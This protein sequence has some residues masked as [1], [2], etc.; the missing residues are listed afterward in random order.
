[1][2]RRELL[3]RAGALGLS[4]TGLTA[5]DAEGRGLAP[6]RD[7]RTWQGVRAQW[8][9]D[10][11]RRNLSTFLLAS[12][13]APV[14]EAIARHRA[15]LD[16]NP[17][18]YLDAAEGRLDGA[19]LDA[20]AAYLAVRR[21][22]IAL[23]DSTTMGLGLVYTGFRLRA[24]DEV[25]TSVHDF[26]A[27][28]ESLRFAA[29]RT[30]ATV[31]RIGLYAKP[32]QATEDEIVVNVERALTARTRLVALTWVHSSTG[33][34]L[35]VRAIS[36]AVRT[37]APNALLAIDGVH[38]VGVEDERPATL[39]C[40]IL[41]SG[42][43]KWLFGP[44]GTGFVWAS[45]RAWAQVRPTIPSFDG[46]AYGGWLTGT[47]SDVPPG[48]LMTPGG[49][50]AFEHRWALADAFRFHLA[51]GRGRV[52]ARTHALG[53]RLAEGLAETAGIRLVTPR[54]PALSGGLV[55]FE[56]AGRDARDVVRALGARRVVATVTPY[57][58]GYV[59]LGPSIANSEVDVDAAIA[60]V[61]AIATR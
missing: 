29:E 24:E 46:R 43:H 61:R 25:V 53:R 27:T 59:R 19:V 47:R 3:A 41:V 10:P 60:A 22:E 15:R 30:G 55:C 2:N 51:I 32:A 21:D 28:H 16:A 5:A 6:P 52:A 20:A 49:Y 23:T 14:R 34:K 50:K 12:N 7:L 9:L 58:E 8:R 54:A 42:A 44:R 17:R 37:R 33:V 38:G 45:P 26:Y 11:A 57:R 4:A 18:G 31:R 13:P 1:V 36:R 40:D 39:G 56:V 48:P 35:P